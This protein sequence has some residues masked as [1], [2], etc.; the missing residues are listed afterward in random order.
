M[1]HAKRRGV[2]SI[3]VAA[4][5]I[6]RRLQLDEGGNADHR[7]ML[8][9]EISGP[10]TTHRSIEQIARKITAR[11]GQNDKVVLNDTFFQSFIKNFADNT[12]GQEIYVDKAHNPDDGVMGKVERL[13]QDGDRFLME[14]SWSDAGVEAYNKKGFKYFSIDFSEDYEDR[15]T[16]KKHGPLLFGV[17]MTPRPFIKHMTPSQGPGRF[18]LSEGR[19]TFVPDYLNIEGNT[20]KLAAL[21]KKLSDLMKSKKLAATAVG[22]LVKQMQHDAEAKKLGDSDAD[23]LQELYEHYLKLGEDLAADAQYLETDPGT[24]NKQLS[25]D[26]ISRVVLATLDKREK[27]SKTLAD[28]ETANRKQ[29]A[30]AIDAQTGLSDE[31]K[32]TLKVQASLVSG[33]LSNDQVKQLSDSVIELGNQ[34]EVQRKRANL[35]L[36]ITGHLPGVQF[37]G[38]G[39]GSQLH[40]LLREKLQLSEYAS[41]LALPEEKNLPAFARKVLAIFDGV[42]GQR[43]EAERKLLAGDGSTNIADGQFPVAAQRQVLVEL[44]ADLRILELVNTLTDPTATAT[45]QIP[46]EVRNVSGIKDGAIVYEGQGI[47]FAGVTQLMDTAYITPR[48]LALMVSDEMIHFSRNAMINWDAWGRNIASNVRLM[49]DLIA[50]AI[51]NELQRSADAFG[52]IEIAAEVVTGQVN[53]VRTLF[54]T[55][56]FPVV[57]PKQIRDLQGNAVGNSQNPVV[58]TVGGTPL[59][60]WDGTGKQ[61]NGNYV[62]FVDYNLGFYRVVNQ[63]GVVQVVP[64]ATATTLRY[65]HATNVV[66]FDLDAPNDVDQNVHL[67]DLLNLVGRVK[68]KLQQERFVD[69]QF[70]LCS[71][72]LHNTITEAKQFEANSQ[73]PGNGLNSDGDLERVKGV[74]MFSTNQPGVDISDTR[75]ILG[76]RQTGTYTIAKPF[77]IGAPFEAVDGDGHPT[78][79]KIAYGIEYSAIH[80]PAPIRN[81][82]SSIIA[83]SATARAAA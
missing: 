77:S 78:A 80:V 15:E 55:A 7:F 23:K 28:N 59:Q 73:K 42:H 53:G 75:L 9:G 43:I 38:G 17:A 52:A 67:N 76:Q 41:S 6:A 70:G 26:D 14:M 71:S 36:N 45:A 60:P 65:S 19:S 2:A 12:Y 63:A 48:K 44:L 62:H 8:G 18:A 79:Q 40:G 13:F 83:Y 11:Y 50:V 56:Q 37:G 34:I 30:D 33:S 74:P 20:M 72:T 1:G 82:M 68:A 27:D 25:E 24:G 64:D 51:G 29:F 81:R 47:P 5:L 69:V 61:A 39:A 46:Y 10:G 21:L 57:R 4:A 16:G 58:L 66:K 49:K 3:G 54:K 32:T 35:G 31:T 22:I